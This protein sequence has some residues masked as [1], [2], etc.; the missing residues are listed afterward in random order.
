MKSDNCKNRNDIAGQSIDLE[1]HVCPGDTSVQ[2]L[3]K[4]QEFVSE[5]RRARE[6]VQRHHNWE[7]QTVQ[8]K[9]PAQAKEKWLLTQQDSDL[10]IGVSVVQGQKKRHGNTVNNDNFNCLQTQDGTISRLE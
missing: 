6:H 9:R 4:L 3:R 2:P 5:T 8:N 10:V 7:S 1:W